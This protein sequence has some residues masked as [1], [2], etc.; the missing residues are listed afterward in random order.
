M[1]RMNDDE[2]PPATEPAEWLRDATRSAA[3]A[4]ELWHQKRYAEAEPLYERV[5]QTY[6]GFLGPNDP[7]LAGA[8]RNLANVRFVQERYRKAYKLYRRAAA[9]YQALD[10][11]HAE[12]SSTLHWVGR[13]AFEAQRYKKAAAAYERAVEL[14][15][16]A[17]PDGSPEL[18]SQLMSL[19]HLYYFVGRHA[20]AEPV[21]LRALAMAERLLGPNDAAVG[22]CAGRIAVL[23]R[24][25]EVLG[26]DP[27]PYYRRAV[28]IWEESG[29]EESLFEADYRLADFLHEAGRDDEAEPYYRRWLELLERVGDRVDA[30]DTWGSKTQWMKNGYLDYLRATGRASEADALATGWGTHDAYGDMIRSQLERFEAALGPDDPKLASALLNVGTHELCE[31]EYDEAEQKFSRA[32]GILERSRGPEHPEVADGL[33]R[34]AAVCRIRERYDEAERHLERA[35]RILTASPGSEGARAS[36]VEQHAT[37]RAARGDVDGAEALY[38]EALDV[39]R[40]VNGPESYQVAEALFHFAAFALANGRASQAADLAAEALKMAEGDIGV[41]DLEKADYLDLYAGA[42]R[43]LG[44]GD[45]A[46]AATAASAKIWDRYRAESDEA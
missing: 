36:L 12:L 1:G 39:Y 21:Y 10:P 26:K 17:A 25:A 3:E 31:G 43:E 14:L 28:G 32:L 16:T 6:E 11:E 7:D 40:R 41:A 34:L 4:A 2:M 23:Y 20:E 38:R 22:R 5:L 13:S 9:I 44:R 8:L 45:E 30:Q 29:D 42:L 37:L 24:N 18:Q 19:A 33:S 27:E 15:E 35:L 46:D